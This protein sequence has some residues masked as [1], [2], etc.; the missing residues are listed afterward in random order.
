MPLI[1]V[2]DFPSRSEFQQH[3]RN[4]I[5][6]DLVDTWIGSSPYQIFINRYKFRLMEENVYSPFD[7][8]SGIKVDELLNQYIFEV[9]QHVNKIGIKL[10]FKMF[11]NTELDFFSKS[12]HLNYTIQQVEI[13]QKYID[14]LN[15]NQ[16]KLYRINNLSLQCFANSPKISEKLSTISKATL[17]TLEPF[18][19][20]TARLFRELDEISEVFEKS[21]K[22]ES[23]E[24]MQHKKDFSYLDWDYFKSPFQ[25]EGYPEATEEFI[26]AVVAWLREE[27]YERKKSLYWLKTPNTYL[28]I[29]EFIEELRQVIEQPKQVAQYETKA[30]EN[31]S[32][33]IEN[34]PKFIFASQKGYDFF[35]LLANQATT[36]K[37][38]S[39]IFRQMSEKEKP[40]MIVVKDKAFRDWFNRESFP[41]TLENFTQTYDKSINADRLWAY[42]I[43]KYLFFNK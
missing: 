31:Q 24:A 6:S 1:E 15:Q 21:F 33:V 34:Y 2:R 14:F 30:L 32:V 18:D 4:I 11:V 41:L 17:L 20:Q 10:D 36:P 12:S 5:E 37:Q 27:M 9:N 22:D 40:L 3:L 26:R 8:K 29:E 42:D 25:L 7:N 19:K 13:Q 43:A 38:L 28:V 39:F 35:S 23:E 16:D